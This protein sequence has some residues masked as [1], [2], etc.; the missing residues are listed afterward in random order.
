MSKEVRI[1]VRL[2]DTDQAALDELVRKGELLSDAVRRIIRDAADRQRAQ[3]AEIPKDPTKIR[4]FLGA[5]VA[6]FNT[7]IQSWLAAAE[8][9]SGASA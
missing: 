7:E 9:K 5:R 1:T 6:A 2:D 3:R 8:K 4:A